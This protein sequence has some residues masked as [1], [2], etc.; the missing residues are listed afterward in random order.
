MATQ[1]Y[2]A[3]LRGINVGGKN[4]IKMAELKFCFEHHGY[5]NVSTYI[6][7]G[8]VIFEAPNQSA[9]D[10]SKK[11][12]EMLSTNFNYNASVVV[13]SADQLK[14]IVASAPKSFGT[15]PANFRYYVLFLKGPLTTQQAMKE[16]P[17]R[18]D[19]DEAWPGAEGVVFHS[20][21]EARA[22]QSY[23]GRLIGMPIYQNITIRNWNT[24]K[25]LE[26]LLE[27]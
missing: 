11:L 6:Q 13:R 10:L 23:L 8:N 18:Q 9:D 16:I 1:K 12:E 15:D 14:K 4:I 2:L 27:K 5:E 20:R 26:A 22:T 24:T 3:L 19:V 17:I 25:K 7:S 21:V